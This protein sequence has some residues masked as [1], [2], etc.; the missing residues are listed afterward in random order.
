MLWCTGRGARPRCG[1]TLASLAVGI[2]SGAMVCQASSPFSAQCSAVDRCNLE[3]DVQELRQN[4]RVRTRES[5]RYYEVTGDTSREIWQQLRGSMNPLSEIPAVGRKP[6]GNASLAYRY[7]YQPAVDAGFSV[8]RIMSGEIEVRLE[9]VLPRL[10]GLQDK[11]ETLQRKWQS[12]QSTIIEHEA[13]HLEILRGMAVLLPNALS[14]VDAESCD[15]LDRKIRSTVR[16]IET[17]IER[18]SL[19]YD[20]SPGHE[21]A[22][23]W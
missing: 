13:G 10:R 15:E 17:A 21:I 12:F 19:D 16:Q 5:T 3:V 11:P 23:G 22:M 7:S 4:F 6:F 14:R 9:I 1:F 8:C 2:V 20:H 18:D